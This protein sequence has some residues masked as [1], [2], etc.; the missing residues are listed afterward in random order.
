MCRLLA[1]RAWSAAKRQE[2]ACQNSKR[3]HKYWHPDS[4]YGKRL[5]PDILI[6]SGDQNIILDTKWK[7]AEDSGGVGEDDLRQ[8]FVYN[9]YFDAA[10]AFLIYPGKKGHI[11]FENGRFSSRSFEKQAVTLKDRHGGIAHV[12]IL[13]DRKLNKRVGDEILHEL[14][15]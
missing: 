7:N 15:G 14:F 11:R 4:G 6:C 8:L 1:L 2:R 9:L 5:E 3:R 12:D 10:K 13:K